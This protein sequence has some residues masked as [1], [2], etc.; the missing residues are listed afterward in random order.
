[1]YV[2]ADG[3]KSNADI[4]SGCPCANS[5]TPIDRIVPFDN[6]IGQRNVSVH[7]GDGKAFAREF[8]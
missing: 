2:S 7:P 4:A 1:M 8:S 3:D 6:N 5:P